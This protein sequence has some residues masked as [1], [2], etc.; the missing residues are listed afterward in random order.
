MTQDLKALVDQSDREV[1]LATQAKPAKTA[2]RVTRVR[3]VSVETADFRVHG[4]HEATPASTDCLA[5]LA[6]REPRVKPALTVTSDLRD[7]RVSVVMSALLDKLV[8]LDLR[9]PGE[10]LDYPAR[11]DHGDPMA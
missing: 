2:S 11:R 10:H 9:A 7:P 8:L 1:L 4:V 3:K 5:Q 6:P